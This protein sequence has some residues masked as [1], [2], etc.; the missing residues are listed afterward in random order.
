MRDTWRLIAATALAALLCWGAALVS[1]R[2]VAQ[3]GPPP[4]QGAP[5]GGTDPAEA[6]LPAEPSF[7][8]EGEGESLRDSADNNVSFP[9]DI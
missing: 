3:Q 2:A 7:G 6:P 1:L 5:A 4:A 8:A 9:V